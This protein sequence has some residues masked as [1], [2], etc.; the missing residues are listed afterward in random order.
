MTYGTLADIVI[1]MKY[2]SD[3]VFDRV[4]CYP[5]AECLLHA[6]LELL[7]LATATSQFPVAIAKSAIRLRSPS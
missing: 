4:L 1:A 6:L 7:E 3:E 2:C 5:P